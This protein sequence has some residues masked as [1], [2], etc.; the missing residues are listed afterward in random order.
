V[1]HRRT[2]RLQRARDEDDG[3]EPARTDILHL[4][5]PSLKFGAGG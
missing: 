5:I 4:A 3:V 2:P 1:V